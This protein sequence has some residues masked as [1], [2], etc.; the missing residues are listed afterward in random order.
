MGR[1]GGWRKSRGGLQLHMLC[2]ARAEK[3]IGHA[4]PKVWLPYTCSGRTTVPLYFFILI[5]LDDAMHQVTHLTAAS[6]ARV[7]LSLCL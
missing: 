5:L 2:N 7:S 6:A 1:R 3:T 4:I